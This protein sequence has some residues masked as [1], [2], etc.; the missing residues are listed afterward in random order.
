MK[1][2]PNNPEASLC[3][4]INKNQ[5]PSWKLF[6]RIMRNSEYYKYVDLRTSSKTNIPL[7]I[8]SDCC[9]DKIE[10][11]KIKDFPL[12]DV[13]CKCGKTCLIKWELNN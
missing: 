1:K 10:V 6:K 7:T 5:K 11:R 3:I 8:E 13:K 12:V 4:K 2:K 9:H